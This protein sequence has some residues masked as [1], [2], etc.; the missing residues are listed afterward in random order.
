MLNFSKTYLYKQEKENLLNL[1]DEMQDRVDEF[2]KSK[3]RDD[4]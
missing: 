3:I 2:I 4:N 1:V